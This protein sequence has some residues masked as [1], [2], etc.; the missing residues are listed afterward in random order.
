MMDK[1]QKKS[2]QTKLFGGYIEK[3]RY[4]Y[5]TLYCVL[6]KVSKTRLLKTALFHLEEQLKVNKKFIPGAIK[7]ISE[8]INKEWG[9]YKRYQLFSC[10]QE[11]ISKEF[12]SF[13]ERQN[14]IL[15]KKGITQKSVDLILK[16]I[17]NE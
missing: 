11:K 14:Q 2:P 10:N 3:E 15:I 13:L 1:K 6:N 9:L 4:D 8:E 12:I 17:I 16:Q 7:Q 5:L